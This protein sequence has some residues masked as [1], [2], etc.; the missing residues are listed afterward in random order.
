MVKLEKLEHQNQDLQQE[1]EAYQQQC[2]QS[3]RETTAQLEE[4]LENAQAQVKELSVQASLAERKI[5]SLEEQ[6]SLGGAKCRELEL[7]LSG[8]YSTLRRTVCTSQTRLLSS[9]AS[10]K[11]SPSPWRNHLQARGMLMRFQDD[12]LGCCYSLN[13]HAFTTV[14]SG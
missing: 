7:K 11:R 13:A 4:A 6:L 3:H 14:F 12:V 8:L 9:Q 1:R 5:Q 2:E 10:C